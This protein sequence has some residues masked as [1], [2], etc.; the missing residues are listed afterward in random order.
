MD[1]RSFGLGLGLGISLLALLATGPAELTLPLTGS[2][3]VTQAPDNS[4]A[5]TFALCG[6]NDPSTC[7]NLG[8]QVKA[9]SV[10]VAIA[11]DQGN[12][13]TNP[14]QINGTTIDTNSGNKS[15]GTQ[16]VVI[17][18]DQPALTNPQP[19]NVQNTPSVS[20]SNAPNI[21]THTQQDILNDAGTNG[22]TTT[23]FNVL[24]TELNA[25]A[26]AGV[27]TS[28]VN[29]TSGKFSQ[30]ST[31]NA[32]FGRCWATLGGAFASAA[33]AGASLSIWFLTSTDGGTTFESQTVSP[34]P[35]P[36]DITIP[37]GAATYAANA[38]LLSPPRQYLW[39][40]TVKIVLQNNTGQAM[41]ASGN[42]V[43]CGPE[44]M[45]Q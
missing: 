5:S 12:V 25:L 30:S 22:F 7:L 38:V 19:V 44:A 21:G 2:Y 37:V 41:P 27:A 36:A 31:G 29:G 40:E 9:S 33:S 1:K 35:R 18:T 14:S 13:S 15:A 34:P 16:R 26:N 3:R 43:T 23:P 10:P 17:A 32:V 6:I 45:K 42:V 20:V 8:Q 4:F 24:T 11:S 28:S 39:S